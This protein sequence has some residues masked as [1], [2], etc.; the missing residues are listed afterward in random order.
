MK[1]EQVIAAAELYL[2]TVSEKMSAIPLYNRHDVRVRR[3][4][5][6]QRGNLFYPFSH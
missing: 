3:Y 1:T 5:I 2:Y 6:G 4:E